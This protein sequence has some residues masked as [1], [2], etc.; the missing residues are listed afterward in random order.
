MKIQLV[1]ASWALAALLAPN[2]CVAHSFDY[3]IVGAGTCGLLVANRLSQD[4]GTSVAL[5]DP[6]ADERN[7]SV[8]T[9][10]AL[11]TRIFQT[12]GINWAY[13]SVPQPAAAG[14]VLTSHAGRGIGGSSLINGA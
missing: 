6:G 2:L 7:N 10:P 4:P 11:F 1:G 5:I 12:P 14:R 9:D 13:P 8:I 3:V